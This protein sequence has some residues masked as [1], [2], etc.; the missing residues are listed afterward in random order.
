MSQRSHRSRSNRDPAIRHSGRAHIRGKIRRVWRPRYLEL[1][2]H[3]GW[4]T[5]LHFYLSMMGRELR[6]LIVCF[7]LGYSTTFSVHK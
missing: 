7:S 5:L 1:V 6:F 4:L 3:I 2:R